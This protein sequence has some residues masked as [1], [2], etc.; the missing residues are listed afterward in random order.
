MVRVYLGLPTYFI[1]LLFFFLLKFSAFLCYHIFEPEQLLLVILSNK[2]LL[3][4]SVL[5]WLEIFIFILQSKAMG[6]E[7]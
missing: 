6:I 1:F 5:V 4:H 2:S 3:I 7:F